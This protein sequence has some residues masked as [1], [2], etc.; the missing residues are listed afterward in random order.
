MN[1]LFKLFIDLNKIGEEGK[2]ILKKVKEYNQK[3]NIK[4]LLN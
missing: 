3:V 2:K 1:I 4:Y